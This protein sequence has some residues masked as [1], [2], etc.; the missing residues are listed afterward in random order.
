[1]EVFWGLRTTARLE[2]E[3][4]RVWTKLTE[5]KA[6]TG[7]SAPGHVASSLLTE[8]DPKVLSTAVRAGLA[9]V[10]AGK[11]V[12]F[13]QHIQLAVAVHRSVKCVRDA[14]RCEAHR[15][16]GTVRAKGESRR[17]TKGKCTCHA[18]ACPDMDIAERDFRRYLAVGE[19]CAEFPIFCYLMHSDEF[20]LAWSAFADM[21]NVVLKA[22]IWLRDSGAALASV[23]TLSDGPEG[24]GDVDD[25][26][27]DDDGGGDGDDSG[28]ANAGATG[29]GG[30]HGVVSSRSGGGSACSSRRGK[31]G[32]S[33]DDDNV[34]VASTAYGK[35]G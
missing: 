17:L 16:K 4:A 2:A 32:G 12:V 9:A 20:K 28:D 24:D 11:A 18:E 14:G 27:D 35:R 1:M 8:A 30:A 26:D 29:A 23:V 3:A 22:C 6:V 13:A 7:D 34:S 31:G 21:A 10:G 5:S 33:G 19:L 25:G 15:V